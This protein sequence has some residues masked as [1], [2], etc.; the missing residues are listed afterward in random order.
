[1]L[2][3]GL[4]GNIA[5]GKTTVANLFRQWGAV[6]IDAD[7]LVR[8]VQA[9]GTP[10]LAAIARRFGAG[11]VAADGT[12]DRARLRDVVFDDPTA[13]ADLN[14][15]VHPAVE[16]RRQ[17]ILRAA[18]ARDERIVVSDIPLLFEAS[19]PDRFDRIVL[20]DAPAEVRRARLVRL[21]GLDPATADRMIAA[22]ATS[23]PKRA[24]SH[25][26]IDNDGSPEALE[27]RADE[28][29]RALS[30]LA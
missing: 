5:S 20:V 29:W 16:A 8:E 26:I 12:F 24:R 3:V 18:R 9:P 17:E 25:F 2:S 28:V 23:G 13:L 11:I 19:N 1:M 27:A 6:V 21:R 30:A 10:V 15:I 14:A 4:T 7:A 22:Q